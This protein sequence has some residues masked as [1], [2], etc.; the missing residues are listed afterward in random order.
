VSVDSEG[1]A[2]QAR[3]RGAQPAPAVPA[4]TATSPGASRR[5]AM[6]LLVSCLG[7]FVVFLDTTIVNI[8]FPTVI[9]LAAGA[10]PYAL[11]DRDS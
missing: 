6:V 2:A 8:A 5:A 4:G 9:G 1:S 11:P 7:V 3:V 10:V